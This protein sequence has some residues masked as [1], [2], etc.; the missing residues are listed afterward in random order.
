MHKL[1]HAAIEHAHALRGHVRRQHRVEVEEIEVKRPEQLL[2]GGR[3]G[4]C[5][6]AV[7]GFLTDVAVGRD[8][9]WRS[10]TPCFAHGR[11]AVARH[12]QGPVC[13]E[14]RS[15]V[16]SQQG[17]GRHTQGDAQHLTEPR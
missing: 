12:E 9:G 4:L 3:V 16:S 11:K 1:G 8:E 10:N 2:L 7:D 14:E 6:G 13:D 17:A 15:V 5:A